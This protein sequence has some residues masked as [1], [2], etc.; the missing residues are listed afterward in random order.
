MKHW[1]FWLPLGL[2]ALFIIVVAFG[3]IKPSDTTIES[4]MI[5]KALPQFALPA[6]VA[7]RPGLGTTEFQKG[8]PR[9]LNIFASWCVPCAAEA[10]QLAALKEAGVAIDGIAIRD[11]RQDLDRFLARWG[12]PYARIGSDVDSSVQIA[13]GSSG[14]PETFVI[15]GKGMIAYQHI[16]EIRREHVPMLLAKLRDA[17]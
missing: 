10:P 11:S 14:V 12:N 3:I 6:A 4:R 8:K 17:Q 2:F 5:G 1:V 9:L 15:D 7:D 16:G 13:L